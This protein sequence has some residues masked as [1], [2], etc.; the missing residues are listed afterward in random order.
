[1]SCGLLYC[2]SV[3]WYVCCCMLCGF[4][5]ACGLLYNTWSVVLYV[6]FLLYVAV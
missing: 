6:G 3:V 1:M 4:Y 5:M 2:M